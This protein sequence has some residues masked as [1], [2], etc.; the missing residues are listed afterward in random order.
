MKVRLRR[1]IERHFRESHKPR[2]YAPK[3]KITVGHL[4]YLSRRHLGRTVGIVIR[5]RLALE[6]RR[7]LL[8]SD[9]TSAEVG[10]ALG[11]KDPAYFAR[12]FKRETGVTPTA[13]RRGNR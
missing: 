13:F 7:Q 10:Y 2:E 9:A 11:F 4:N 6:A 3:L 12:F 5:E 1:L 8:H